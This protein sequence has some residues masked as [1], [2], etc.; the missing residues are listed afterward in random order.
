MCLCK[1]VHH[2]CGERVVVASSETV[3]RCPLHLEVTAVRVNQNS[4]AAG[5]K[6]GGKKELKKAIKLCITEVTA[7][8]SDNS[9]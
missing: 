7:E 6:T 3:C 8:S 4:E 1:T 9:V 2:T 5:Q